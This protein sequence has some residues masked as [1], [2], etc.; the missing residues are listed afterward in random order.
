MG[1]RSDPQN[2]RGT[3]KGWREKDQQASPAGDQA[4]REPARE[5][6]P[7][8]PQSTAVQPGSTSRGRR[9]PRKGREKGR[10]GRLRNQAVHTERGRGRVIIEEGMGR[11][12]LVPPG[13]RHTMNRTEVGEQAP[14][15]GN[16]P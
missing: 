8:R 11:R 2:R 1:I 3:G 9:R 10:K 5:A 15:A 14:K 4:R 7:Y 6:S 12:E 16:G 13:R